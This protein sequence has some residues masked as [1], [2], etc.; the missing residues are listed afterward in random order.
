[1]LQAGE[2][3]C[4][5]KRALE[6]LSEYANSQGRPEWGYEGPHNSGQYDSWPEVQPLADLVHLPY[7]WKCS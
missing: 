5:D 2:F 6:S 7:S 1:M 4:Y 3:Q